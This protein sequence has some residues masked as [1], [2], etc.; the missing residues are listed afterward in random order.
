MLGREFKSGGRKE[1]RQ[2]L[3]LPVDLSSHFTNFKLA[4]SIGNTF[5]QGL[6]ATFVPGIWINADNIKDGGSFIDAIFTIMNT[7]DCKA[8]KIARA[9]IQAYGDETLGVG[10]RRF[11][12]LF[13]K[14]TP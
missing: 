3:I 10:K 7:R 4:K 1:A 11:Q 14:L 6:S 12:A 9:S 13:K 5:Q 8:D 2:S